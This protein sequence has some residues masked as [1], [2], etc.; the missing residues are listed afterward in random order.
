MFVY[1]SSNLLELWG[2]FFSAVSTGSNKH[3]AKFLVSKNRSSGCLLGWST[4]TKLGA[5]QIHH[6][7]VINMPSNSDKVSNILH[8][9]PEVTSGLGKLINTQVKLNIDTTVKP[10]SHYWRRVPFHIR[11]KIESKIDVLLKLDIIEPV[12]EA[13]PWVSPLLGIPKVPKNP[14]NDDVRIVVDMQ[15]P[16]T[17]IKQTHHPIPTIDETFE[18]FI[19]AQCLT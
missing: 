6:I 14:K 3:I 17:A 2:S 1:G 9:F 18:K 16:N 11:R 8:N 7:N 12:S 19:N 15:K 10:V 4:A 13:T 5:L